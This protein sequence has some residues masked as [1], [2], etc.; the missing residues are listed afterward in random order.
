MAIR[1]IQQSDVNTNYSQIVLSKRAFKPES[2]FENLSYLC[3]LFDV[4]WM[5]K[6]NGLTWN[7]VIDS[8]ARL[9]A[10]LPEMFM[11][12][13][14]SN[15]F[16]PFNWRYLL[17]IPLLTCLGQY[18]NCWVNS[19]FWFY[20]RLENLGKTEIWFISLHEKATFFFCSSV[21]FPFRCSGNI[22]KCCRNFK[23]SFW[24]L[25]L[26]RNSLHFFNYASIYCSQS[27]TSLRGKVHKISSIQ[28]VN[29]IE[30]FIDQTTTKKCVEFL[31]SRLFIKYSSINVT[32]CLFIA[33]TMLSVHS[34]K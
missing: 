11:N 31:C 4:N 15:S 25:S 23:S 34:T 3:Q 13:P 26:F 21:A 28:S 2:P 12:L 30:I 32:I 22:S 10:V 20:F 16:N 18:Y 24:L 8:I 7:I 6:I 1:Q 9:D 29:P 19:C 17:G 33:R 14:F 27:S 5:L